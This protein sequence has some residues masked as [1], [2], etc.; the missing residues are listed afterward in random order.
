MLRLIF[1]STLLLCLA[2]AL[3]GYD[4]EMPRENGTL[5]SLVD[6]HECE[7]PSEPPSSRC[8]HLDLLRKP[9]P[10][11]VSV[12]SCRIE[13]EIAITRNDSEDVESRKKYLPIDLNNC[14]EMQLHGCLRLRNVTFD[15][16]SLN[17]TNSRS[18]SKTD[19]THSNGTR[20]FVNNFVHIV[21]K[22]FSINISTLDNKFMLPSGTRC[23]YSDLQCLDEDGF[24]NF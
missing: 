15:K 8:V 11:D 19:K 22:R 21:F 9:R 5:I 14:L 13:S 1:Q 23:T 3:M 10:T 12:L 17:I 16:L 2:D 7:L 18:L 20:S 4:C 6:L 24:H